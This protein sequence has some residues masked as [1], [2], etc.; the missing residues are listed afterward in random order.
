MCQNFITNNNC[1][2]GDKCVYAHNLRE[3]KI[4]VRRKKILEIILS[5]ENLDKYNPSINK[6]IY[7]ELQNFTKL[8]TD[9]ENGKCTGG[10]NCKF[11]SPDKKY[12]I[13]Y[14]DINYGNCLLENCSKIHLTKRG[15]KP[16]YNN[17]YSNITN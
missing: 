5:D 17:I 7:K 15:L 8:C 13:C 14:D 11:G 16:M 4:D 9:C 6:D 10:Y 2:Y 12:L 1:T 3:Q